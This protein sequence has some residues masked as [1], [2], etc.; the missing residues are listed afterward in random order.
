[1]QI[2]LFAYGRY[3]IVTDVYDS[4]FLAKCTYVKFT[5]YPYSEVRAYPVH[6]LVSNA[7]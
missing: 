2:A 7:E 5:G 4:V 1:M 3:R 6:S